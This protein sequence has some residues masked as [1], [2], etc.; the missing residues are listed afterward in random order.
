M[1][2]TMLRDFIISIYLFVF[3]IFFNFF[4]LFPL[5]EKTTLVATFGG[6]ILFTAKEIENQT[7]DSVVILKSAQCSLYFAQTSRRRVLNFENKNLLHWLIPVYH[8]ATSH[9]VIVDNYYG[10]LAAASFKSSVKCVQIWH[11]VGAIK[12]FGLQDVSTID[13]SPTAQKRFRDVYN[14][15]DYVVTGSEKMGKIFQDSFGLPEERL[16]RTGVPRT[17]F[18]FD[19]YLMSRAE[20]LI[21]E[22]YPAI[23]QKK[24][25]LYAP[26]YR[27]N[28][29]VSPDLPLE[30]D[31][32][33]AALKDEYVL[34]LRLHPAVRGKFDFDKFPDFVFDVSHFPDVNRLL[35]VSDILITDYSSIPFEYALLERPMIFYAYDLV[36]YGET[37]GFWDDYEALVP[38]PIVQSTDEIIKV[39]L[40][41]VYDLDRIKKFAYEWN[42]Y[43]TGISSANLVNHIYELEQPEE[44]V[45]EAAK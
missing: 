30:L 9:V 34:F 32:M 2:H 38:G 21:R 44:I 36:H 33:Y 20:K 45:K 1:V 6:N 19:P 4:K 15:F 26:T 31:R 3:K 16:L 5:K 43:S 35:S 25:I 27:D 8:L 13:R 40:E 22:S 14:R 23:G 24:V 10:F 12:Q 41:D 17:D 7:D 11:A 28:H 37:R 42:K 29:L 39:I 18:F